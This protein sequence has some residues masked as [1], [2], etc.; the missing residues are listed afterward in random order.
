MSTSVA[1]G[2]TDGLLIWTT[3][4]RMQGSTAT[5]A[6]TALCPTLDRHTEVESRQIDPTPLTDTCVSALSRYGVQR[7]TTRVDKACACGTSSERADRR[8]LSA[9][10]G[11]FPCRLQEALF[12]RLAKALNPTKTLGLQSGK[13]GFLQLVL[14]R[15]TSLTWPTRRLMLLRSF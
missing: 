8:K 11:R 5:V 12:C 10:F 9:A 7:H 13:K 6:L 14:A 4:R 15:A 3:T 2:F 1:V